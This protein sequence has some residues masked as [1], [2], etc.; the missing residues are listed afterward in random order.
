MLTDSLRSLPSLALVAAYD[1]LR[2]TRDLAVNLALARCAR[3]QRMSG[4]IR[5][6]S[7]AVDHYGSPSLRLVARVALV[8]TVACSS[9]ASSPSGADPQPVTLFVSNTTCDPGPCT[10]IQVLAFPDNGPSTPNGGWAISLGLVSTPTACLTIPAT[11]SFSVIGAA[12]AGAPYD[13]TTYEWTTADSVAIGAHAPPANG[14]N[15]G[16]SSGAFVPAKAS[17]WAI[18]LPGGSVATS[19]APCSPG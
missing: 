8:A 11:A 12:Q 19:A 18:A 14:L 15:T 16:P 4:V 1:R 13:T 6:V 17:A 5:V 2:L 3:V 10:E 9:S 7:T